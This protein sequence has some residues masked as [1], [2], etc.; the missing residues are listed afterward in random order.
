MGHIAQKNAYYSLYQS[1]KYLFTGV[2]QGSNLITT[3]EIRKF[4]KIVAIA[5]GLL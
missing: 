4:T 1:G 5:L 2:G 3:F